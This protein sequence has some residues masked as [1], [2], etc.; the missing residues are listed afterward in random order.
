MTTFLNSFLLLIYLRK[1]IAYFLFSIVSSFRPGFICPLCT[2]FL[3]R[4]SDKIYIPG[5]PLHRIAY[6]LGGGADWRA[7]GPF[8]K[9]VRVIKQTEKGITIDLLDTNEN[10]AGK[11]E[12]MVIL[13][14]GTQLIYTQNLLVDMSGTLVLFTNGS[15]SY[16]V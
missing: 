5:D 7:F 11:Y 12:V 4:G 15:K 9:R 3:I 6:N 10:D 1:E 14:S 16:L 8:V 2:W 13:K